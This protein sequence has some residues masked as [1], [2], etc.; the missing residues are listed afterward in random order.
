M[1][2]MSKG[3]EQLEQ[4]NEM[5]ASNLQVP[6]DTARYFRN[7][8]KGVILDTPMQ[9]Y[10]EQ[11]EDIGKLNKK[12]WDREG[13]PKE[14]WFAEP[15]E[16][17]NTDLIRFL[18]EMFEETLADQHMPPPFIFPTPEGGITLEWFAEYDERDESGRYRDTMMAE[19]VI[20]KS[21]IVHMLVLDVGGPARCTFF[22]LRD[23][24]AK[25]MVHEFLSGYFK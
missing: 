4:R 16:P 19:F 10:S 12:G 22:D 20:S 13:H 15:A 5:A 24:S 14:V 21:G 8:V 23:S 2:Q 25:Q 18:K 1:S 6:Q 11:I 17:I 3:S 7:G 9:S